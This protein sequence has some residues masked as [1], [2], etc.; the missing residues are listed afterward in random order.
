MNRIDELLNKYFEGKTTLQEENELHAY[1]AGEI[2]KK[3]LEFQPV[4]QYFAIRQDELKKP[5]VEVQPTVS[6]HRQ[7]NLFKWI[8]AAASFAIV[9]GA[10]VHFLS[11]QKNDLSGQSI[12]YVDGKKIKNKELINTEIVNSINSITEDD[13]E[14][15]QSQ[16]DILDAFTN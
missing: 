5:V 2:D 9:V 8:G 4:F 11:I 1:F 16:I 3:H 6:K 13:A 7:I 15:L 12:V 14:L 10:G